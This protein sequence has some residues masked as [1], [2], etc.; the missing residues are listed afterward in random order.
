MPLVEFSDPNK[1]RYGAFKTGKPTFSLELYWMS[2]LAFG[3]G[4]HR[5]TKLEFDSRVP[6]RLVDNYHYFY[7]LGVNHSTSASSSPLLLPMTVHE[8]CKLVCISCNRLPGKSLCINCYRKSLTEIVRMS[9]RIGIHN[10]IRE[11]RG[12]LMVMNNKQRL[13]KETTE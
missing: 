4:I 2:R 12:F 5:K 9:V 8:V 3:H 1:F 11:S 6:K 10:P 13:K 7:E